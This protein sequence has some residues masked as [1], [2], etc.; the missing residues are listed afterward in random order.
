VDQ[1]LLKQAPTEF[2]FPVEWGK[3]R[4][5]AL[6]LLDSDPASPKPDD[7]GDDPAALL[8]PAIMPVCAFRY[9]QDGLPAILRLAQAGLVDRSRLVQ[10]E[11]EFEFH[12]RAWSGEKLSVTEKLAK[13]YDKETSK[14]VLRFFEFETAFRSLDGEPVCMIRTV[15]IERRR[16]DDD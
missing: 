14:E 1:D 10:G 6:A 11:V 8:M 13:V 9:S 4:E 12:R 3:C 2:V 16:K 7:G 15:N 5:F